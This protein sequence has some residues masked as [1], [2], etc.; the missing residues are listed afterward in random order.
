MSEPIALSSCIVAPETGIL[1][2]CPRPVA[3]R[4]EIFADRF[5]WNTLFYDVYRV[6]RDV[7]FQGPPL[8]NFLDLLKQQPPFRGTLRRWFPRARHYSQGKRGEI[9]LRSDA[10]HFTL[11]G[12]LGRFDIA[13]QPSLNP[14][15]AGRRVLMTISKDNQIHWIE[16]WLWYYR[17]VHGAEGALLYDNGSTLYTPEELQARLSASVPDMVV[18]VISWPFPFGAEGGMAGAVGGVEAPW[19]SDYCQ[20]GQQQHAR[21]RCFGQARSVLNVDID[22]FVLPSGGQT[23]FEATENSRHGFTKFEGRWVT[24]ASD[25]A[26][27]PLQCR[28]GDFTRLEGAGAETCPAKWCVVPAAFGR[29]C[30][31]SHHNIFG[32]KANRELSDQFTYRHFQGITTSWKYD[33][34]SEDAPAAENLPED[35]VL[36]D[37]MARAGLVPSGSLSGSPSPAASLGPAPG[38]APAT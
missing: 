9:W 3:L 22:E 13:V 35:G 7:V 2:D 38:P 19:D 34:W 5:D 6:G 18:R 17:A 27:G 33:R 32:T 14:L 1:R 23:I 4:N 8:F 26:P 24:V 25:T 11:D 10:D 31:W 15:F 30:S 37:A 36:K 20:V 16:D 21:F 29:E 28:H 12:P